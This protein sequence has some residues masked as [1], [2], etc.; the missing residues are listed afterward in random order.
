M[1]L[2]D[3]FISFLKIGALSFG[4]GYAM[5]PF[6]EKEITSHNW[7]S[8]A[9]YINVIALVQMLPGPFA[10]NS[11][12]YIG[13]RVGGFLGALSASVALSLPSFVALIFVSKYYNN[14]S[15]NIYMNIALRSIRPAV[16]GLLASAVYIIGIQPIMEKTEVSDI[17]SIAKVV[18]LMAGGFLLLKYTKVKPLIFILI[19]AV[20]G[21]ILF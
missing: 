18:S 8:A 21:I 3:L 6:F 11:S 7:T 12:A 1:K 20:I 4:G 15:S 2:L 9:D 5:V 17:L 16:I 10:I 14:F 19:Y 13:F